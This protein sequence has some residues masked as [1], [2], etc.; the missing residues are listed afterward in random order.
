MKQ[1]IFEGFTLDV[2]KNYI[3]YERFFNISKK[4]EDEKILPT[5]KTKSLLVK[6][7]DLHPSTIEEKT[8]I[9]IDP[10]ILIIQS[11]K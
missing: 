10:L 7:V 1:S 3:T 5:G 4:I 6:Y 9:I 2:L 11:N 8:E